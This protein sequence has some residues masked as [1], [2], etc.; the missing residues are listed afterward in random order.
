MKR[1]RAKLEEIMDSGVKPTSVSELFRITGKFGYI[2][3]KPGTIYFIDIPSDLQRTL[4]SNLQK[5]SQ[6]GQLNS[7]FN[8]WMWEIGCADRDDLAATWDKNPTVKVAWGF[9]DNTFSGKNGSASSQE[10]HAKNV[11][12]YGGD[13]YV[14]TCEDLRSTR[15]KYCRP[16]DQVSEDTI[17]DW[18]E[19]DTKLS[20]QSGWRDIIRGTCDF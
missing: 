12:N 13:G 20:L 15:R 4:P 18:Y 7:R 10:S 8:R 9:L 17:F 16:G 6:V 14:P 2:S 11:V 3:G 19:K 5:H 1:E